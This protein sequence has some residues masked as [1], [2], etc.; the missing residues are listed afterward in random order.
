LAVRC[1]G[2]GDSGWLSA[3]Q[4]LGACTLPELPQLLGPMLPTRPSPRTKSGLWAA[5]GG[6]PAV[7]AP[8]GFVAERL[9]RILL[10]LLLLAATLAAARCALALSAGRL[11]GSGSCARRS[12]AGGAIQ[13]G[14]QVEPADAG[15]QQGWRAP[16]RCNAPRHACRW[17]PDP[18]PVLVPSKL[19]CVSSANADVEAGAR[20]S[21]P[22]RVARTPPTRGVG[23]C[24]PHREGS[25]AV[26]MFCSRNSWSAVRSCSRCL[27]P[28]SQPASQPGQDGVTVSARP[29]A[30]A[31]TARGRRRRQRRAPGRQPLP[32]ANAHASFTCHSWWGPEGR[33]PG[34]ACA[35]GA[36]TGSRRRRSAAPPP[37]AGGRL[38]A[39]PAW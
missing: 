29:P 14:G 31:S 32:L 35:T 13:G 5:A 18:L 39:A 36:G 9:G 3:V 20:P 22:S 10:L 34:A 4:A 2:S 12:R 21:R 16:L 37:S 15:K 17:L 25:Q 11:A 23:G 6:T 24:E 26:S 33:R 7:H 27:Q 28:A 38:G 30:R 19:P 8:P 1:A